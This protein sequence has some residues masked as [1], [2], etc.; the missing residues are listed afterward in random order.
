M[1][2]EPAIPP[3]LATA[4][5][6]DPR[7]PDGYAPPY[8]S[9]VARWAES[10]PTHVDIFGAALRHLSTMGPAARLR[11]YHEVTVAAAGEQSYAYRGCHPRTGMLRAAAGV[12][13]GAGRA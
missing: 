13:A 7:T 2:V 4:R 8:P 5:T 11:L 6:R 3:H 12:P 1:T 10:H 9:Y